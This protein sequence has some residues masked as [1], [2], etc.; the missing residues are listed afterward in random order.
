MRFLLPD[1]A[2][3]TQSHGTNPLPDRALDTGSFRRNVGKIPGLFPA[4]ASSSAPGPGRV[5]EWYRFD[6]HGEAIGDTTIEPGMPG[7]QWSRM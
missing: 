4:N 7:S 6:E 2:G 5:D 3:T 1:G